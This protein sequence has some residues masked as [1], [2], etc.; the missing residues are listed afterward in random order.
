MPNLS[1]E[2]QTITNKSD[3]AENSAAISG[4]ANKNGD[5]NEAFSASSLTSSSI[6]STDI[7]SQTLTCDAIATRILNV[8]EPNAP[9][10]F[11]YTGSTNH[12]AGQN[13]RY[14][15]RLP[16][17]GN[18]PRN[19][20]AIADA[21]I[22]YDVDKGY[23]AGRGD[24][25]WT[26]LPE[27]STNNFMAQ[28]K[29]SYQQITGQGNTGRY[30]PSY[31]ELQMLTGNTARFAVNSG[32]G[33]F[34]DA[35]SW[36]YTSDDRRKVNETSIENA[37]ATLTQLQPVNYYR[38]TEFYDHNTQFTEEELEELDTTYESGFIAQDVKNIPELAHLCSGEEYDENQ[39][40][41]AL[42]IKYTY[43]HAFSVKAIQ[44][45]LA[46]VE[47]LEARIAAVEANQS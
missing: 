45:L 12:G 31:A 44:E 2:N 47:T 9:I 38:T 43:L 41:S 8:T 16:G 28:L 46:K 26:V 35:S 15:Q 39:N 14:G 37:L 40:P 29:W 25:L 30:H 33:G 24:F 19:E 36:N 10:L 27:G 11:A 42:S 3:I 23:Y 18:Q 4:K 6:I 13:P 20:R 34:L 7:Q 32:G 22:T 17:A 21:D 5:S 1:A